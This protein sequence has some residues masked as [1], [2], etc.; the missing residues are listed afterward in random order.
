MHAGAY[1]IPVKGKS[2]RSWG[3]KIHGYTEIGV[4]VASKYADALDR[5][6]EAYQTIWGELPLLSSFQDLTS[7]RP[8]T[9]TILSWIYHDIL[10][11]HREAMK[12]FRGKGK[13]PT[14][15]PAHG[16]EF[17]TTMSNRSQFGNKCSK[18]HGEAS[19]QK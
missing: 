5:L 6:L 14:Q 13:G 18:Q 4:Q 2:L 16:I 17:L 19:A 8:Y 15:F 3:K 12:Y 7:G 1:E 10:D 11:F 9:K